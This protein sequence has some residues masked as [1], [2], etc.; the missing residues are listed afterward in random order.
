MNI[1]LKKAVPKLGIPGEMHTVK[2]GFAYN[3]LIPQGLAV[4]ASK[5]NEAEIE[6]RKIELLKEH[7]AAK[8]VAK[9]IKE[10]MEGKPV[11]FER[12]VNNSGNLYSVINPSEVLDA[13]NDQFKT[14]NF[15][16]SKNNISFSNKIRTYGIFDC[17][18]MLYNDVFAKVKLVISENR[19]A[20]KA[21]FE[22]P[23][24]VVKEIIPEPVAEVASS[25]I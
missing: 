3:Y 20:G 11:F 6:K 4:F 10:V 13:L 17:S 21:A 7:E 24:E 19:N 9:S 14:L 22:R 1:I 15:V 8:I 18:I 16:F 5:E 25:Q 2:D 12:T 23:T